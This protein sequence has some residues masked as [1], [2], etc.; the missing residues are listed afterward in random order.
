MT[1]PITYADFQVGALLGEHAEAYTPQ[2]AQAW[3][4]M[5]GQTSSA[6]NPATDAAEAASI[7][8]VLSMRAYLH[9]VS[10]RP[11]G[12]VHAREQFT[13]IAPPRAGEW[14]RSVVTCLDKSIQRERR[15]VDLEVQG[16][17]DADRPLFSARMRLLWAA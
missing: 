1:S 10:P 12:N 6:D 9:V 13:L 15:C 16:S 11:P 3:R 2:L 14:V 7:A 4:R 17:G 5:F 8:V